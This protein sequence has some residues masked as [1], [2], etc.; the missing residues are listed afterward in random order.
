MAML[1]LL[2]DLTGLTYRQLESRARRCGDRLP[3][4]TIASVLA[5]TTLPRE[6]FTSAL[7]RACGLD[8]APWLT[9]HRG[10]ARQEEGQPVARASVPPHQLPHCPSGLTGHDRELAALSELLSAADTPSPLAVISGPPGVGKS[11][12]AMRAARRVAAHY[13]DGQLYVQLRGTTPDVEP[14]YPGEAATRLLRSLSAPVP[15]LLSDASETATML[16][17]VLAG[18]R[19]LILL[20]DAAS[21]A[22][23]RPLLPAGNRCAVLVTSRSNLTSLD[24]ARSVQ[25]R[26]LPPAEARTVLAQLLGPERV[27]LDPEAVTRLAELCGRLPLCLRVVAARLAARP[28][29]P[30][31][32]LVERLADERHRLDELSVDDLQIRASLAVSYRALPRTDEVAR[33]A[34]RAFL[35]F[36]ALRLPETG[37]T[38]LADL[39]KVSPRQAESAV[40]RLVDSHLLEST[41]PGRYRM[42]DLVRIFAGERAE[43][44]MADEVAAA[45]LAEHDPAPER[46][47]VG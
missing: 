40:E 42:L 23:V 32:A 17:T 37:T 25:L 18:R 6:E 28:C 45:C 2:K 35:L 38:L 15:H 7:V 47:R 44:E 1:R 3:R 19:M 22:Q 34:V 33:T 9:V 31:A 4:S 21:A 11:V 43:L 8:P 41:G 26:P 30:V 14:L 5:R 29:W 20:D 16:R 13:P 10:L 39:L 36:G 46:T 27:A 24:G 12:L